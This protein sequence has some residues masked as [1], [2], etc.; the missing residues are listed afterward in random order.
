MSS[1]DQSEYLLGTHAEEL[2]RLGFQHRVWAR[3]A[4]DLWERAG[5]NPR[6]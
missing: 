1:G 3:E 5:F 4:F 6:G 2:E